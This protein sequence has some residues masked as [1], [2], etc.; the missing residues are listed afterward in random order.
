MLRGLIVIVTPILSMFILGRKQYR[1]HYLGIFLIV[2]GVMFVSYVHVT[3]SIEAS[4]L[5]VFIL[6]LAQ[7]FGGLMLV[8]EEIILSN[9]HLDPFKCVGTEG[10]WG[11]CFFLFLLPI[12]Q[13]I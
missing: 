3:K 1:H 5:G 13:M 8:S 10:M 2:S 6:I 12:F 9:Y 11:C 7:F 4:F